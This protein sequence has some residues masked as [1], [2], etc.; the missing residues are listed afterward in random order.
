MYVGGSALLTEAHTPAERGKTQAANDFIVFA[1]MA[2]SS[3]SSGM[4]LH[5]SGWHAVNFG[6]IPFLAIAAVATL[7]LMWHRRV[8]RSPA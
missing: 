1:V 3:A 4:L 6:S 7:W 2:I 5:Q 8:A